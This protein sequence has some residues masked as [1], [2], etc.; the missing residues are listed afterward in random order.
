MK[1]ASPDSPRRRP[2]SPTAGPGEGNFARECEGIVMVRDCGGIA[3]GLRRG[4]EGIARGLSSPGPR[5]SPP[6]AQGPVADAPS[7]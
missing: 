2:G 5:P 4:C 1:R 7:P 6:N 3:K